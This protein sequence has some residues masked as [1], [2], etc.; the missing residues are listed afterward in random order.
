MIHS[1]NARRVV[2][3]VVALFAIFLL[4][5][6]FTTAAHPQSART[7]KKFQNYLVP[8]RSIQIHDGFGINSDLPRDPYV[9]WNRWWWTRIFDAGISFIRIGQYE[10]SS[11]PTSWDWVERKRGEYSI[12]QEV[13]DQ[14]DSLVENG[15]HIEI[16]LL[17]GNPLYTSPAGRAPQ[18]VTPAP[19]ARSA[20]S[21]SVTRCSRTTRS[22]PRR[23][24]RRAR[25]R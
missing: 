10:N 19:G 23:A 15:V 8:R 6:G 18:T 17:Y 1:Y 7:S 9:P 22:S 25:I 14:I 21:R 12:A 20:A 3:H 4:A 11:D 24:T 5:L 2:S 13:D 16:Q